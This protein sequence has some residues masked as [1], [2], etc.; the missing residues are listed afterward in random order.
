MILSCV[1]C[2]CWALFPIMPSEDPKMGKQGSAGTIKRIMLTIPQ[3]L[4]IIWRLENSKG[5]VV[6]FSCNTRSSIIYVTRKKKDQDQLQSLMASNGSVEVFFKQQTL[7]QHKSVQLDMVICKWFSSVF[8]RK[9]HDWACDNWKSSVFLWWNGNNGQMN[10]LQRLAVKLKYFLINR[11]FHNLASVSS[12][13][14]HIYEFY[15]S[16]NPPYIMSSFCTDKL[17]Y[18]TQLPAIM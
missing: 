6:M 18:K 12:Y 8:W 4:K 1:I 13:G 17:L 9:P 3:K 14:C 7:T 2:T 5:R 15:H 11:T 10:V 16:M